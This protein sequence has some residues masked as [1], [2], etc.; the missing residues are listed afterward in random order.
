MMFMV[1]VI[2]KL[3]GCVMEETFEHMNDACE[4]TAEMAPKFDT[5]TE[6]VLD[7]IQ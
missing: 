1:Y 3:D 4:W 7:I 5:D 2:D 6:F